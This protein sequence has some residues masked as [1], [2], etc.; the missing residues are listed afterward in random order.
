MIR[1]ALPAGDLRGALAERLAQSGLRVNGYGEGSR[2]YKLRVEDHE[3]VDVRVFREKDIPIQIALGNYDLGICNIAWIEEMQARFPER[4]LVPLRDMGV[5]QLGVYAAAAAGAF[6]DL[7]ELGSLKPVR[8]ASEFPNLANA[9]A[10]A[11]RF[12][13]YRVQATWGA[14]GGYPPEDADLAIVSS[15]GETKL[16]EEGLDPLFCLL[17]NSAWLIAGVRSLTRKNLAPLLGQLMGAGA[18]GAL[19][20]GLSMPRPVAV[21]TAPGVFAPERAVVRMA[22]PDGHQ[23]RHVAEALR[24]AGLSFDGYDKERYLRRPL[25]SIDGL[26]IKVVR[27]H[28]MPQLI[29]MGEIDL[30]ITGRDC[31]ME[32]L[33]QFPSSPVGELLDLQTG[34]FNL[35]AV[36]SQEVKAAT[37]H[38]AVDG[39]RAEG[40]TSLKIA[41]EFPAIAD[42]YARS[43]HLWRYQVIP[44]AGASEG[45]V[46]EDAELLIEGTETGRTLAENNL[47]PID[48]L[49]R[50][51]TCLI[52]R[53][54]RDAA[55][56]RREVFNHVLDLLGSL[57]RSEAPA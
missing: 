55:G 15:P 45:F 2:T 17:E 3:T 51:T 23:Q 1:L 14:A 53:T 4:P 56:R 11:A 31:L 46:P 24:Q 19:G 50:S 20:R 16:R 5:G 33:Y 26:A 21:A 49:F 43:R 18:P 6:K 38:E 27:P 28:D 22:L 54:D 44:I 37:I 29:A 12:P 52:G 47:K 30:A 42:H 32:H 40:K 8:V 9:F 36:V 41:S 7:N 35:S 39:W 10:T 57:S 13:A 34:Q 25:S 48:L